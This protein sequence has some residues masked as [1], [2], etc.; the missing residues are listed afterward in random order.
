MQAQ[1]KVSAKVYRLLNEFKLD[2]ALIELEN[3][4]SPEQKSCSTEYNLTLTKIYILKGLFSLAEESLSHFRNEGGALELFYLEKLNLHYLSGDFGRWRTTLSQAQMQMALHETFQFQ[5]LDTSEQIAIVKHFEEAGF[6]SETIAFYESLVSRQLTDQNYLRTQAQL[7][8]LYAIWNIKSSLA[9]AYSQLL[10]L[11]PHELDASLY[12]EVQHSLL[13]AET[14]LFGIDA[15]LKRLKHSFES[16]LDIYD[17]KLLLF[18]FCELALSM[19]GSIP[20]VD[21]SIIPESQLDPYEIE[22]KALLSGKKRLSLG[23][24]DL[25]TNSLF[26]L[27]ILAAKVGVLLSPNTLESAMFLLHEQFAGKTKRFWRARF[28]PL[29]SQQDSV[30][31]SF[32]N[33]ELNIENHIYS[34]A[35]QKTLSELLSVICQHGPHVQLDV[36]TQSL[37][38]ESPNIQL[39]DRLRVNINR[40]NRMFEKELG[41]AKPFKIREGS[42]QTNLRFCSV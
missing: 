8:R 28:Q 36:L 9:T 40:L 24:S 27:M 29:F 32:R 34:L 23:P 11:K 17:Q 26:R 7:V 15:G 42:V 10:L 41:I 20:P 1:S 33:H 3:L 25:P 18:D 2:E 13:L 31:V 5:V 30:E 22:V 16:Q 19:Y 14:A 37:Y 4:F 38:N 21:L 12:V 6:I 39:L 35:N